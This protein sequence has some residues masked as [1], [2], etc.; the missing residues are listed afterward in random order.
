[1]PHYRIT[2]GDAIG[3][4]ERAIKLFGGRNGIQEI[5]LIEAAIARPY[6]GYYRPIYKKAAAFIQS[7]SANHGFVDGNKRTAFML[8]HLLLSRSGYVFVGTSTDEIDDIEHLITDLTTKFLNLE[9]MTLWL[10]HRI[11]KAPQ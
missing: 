10:K 2:L 1:M 6:T 9:E 3:A 4:H 11:Q 5:G 7:V 8:F